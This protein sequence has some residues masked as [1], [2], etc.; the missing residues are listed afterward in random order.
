[1]TIRTFYLAAALLGT[2][3]PWLF[4][5]AFFATNGLDIPLLLRALFANDPAAGISADVLISIPV[6]WLWSWRDARRHGVTR[7]RLVL[8]ASFCVDLSLA[9]QLYLR[10]RDCPPRVRPDAG[11]LPDIL[12]APAAKPALLPIIQSRHRRAAAAAIPSLPVAQ[13]FID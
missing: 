11:T 1:M 5:G 4:L 13:K 6:F 2:L 7:W 8:P 10:E 9:R 3:V 12:S